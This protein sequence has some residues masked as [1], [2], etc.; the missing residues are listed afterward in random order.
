MEESVSMKKALLIIGIV[1]LVACVL[2]LI[3]ALLFRF[4]YFHVLDGSDAL[5]ERLHRWMTGSFIT[6]G[7]LAV[8]G[9]TCLLARLKM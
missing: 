7:I 5:Y 6:S 8:L 9:V 2:A 3:V 1:I 4:S